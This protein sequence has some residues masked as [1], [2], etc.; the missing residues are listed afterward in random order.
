MEGK[1]LYGELVLKIFGFFVFVREIG[2]FGDMDCIFG[3]RG[4]EVEVC[5][6]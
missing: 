3:C 2:V 5:G 6:V 1:V 4:E